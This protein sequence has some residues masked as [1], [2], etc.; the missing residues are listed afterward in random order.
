MPELNNILQKYLQDDFENVSNLL[1]RAL[2]NTLRLHGVRKGLNDAVNETAQDSLNSEA[3]YDF[4]IS[5]ARES[6][7]K[8]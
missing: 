6:I 3:V 5:K 8:N 1:E 2:I 4:V 7:K